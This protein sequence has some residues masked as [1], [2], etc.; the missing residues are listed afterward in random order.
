MTTNPPITA[1]D[2]LLSRPFERP[3][4]P[5]LDRATPASQAAPHADEVER[6]CSARR[7][8]DA[9]LDAI[10]ELAVTTQQAT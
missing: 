8:S 9:A 7:L 3:L 10:A 5:S 4:D 2:R 6:Q 1:A